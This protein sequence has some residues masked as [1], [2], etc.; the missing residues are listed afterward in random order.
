MITKSAR[1]LDIRIRETLPL[2]SGLTVDLQ[3]GIVLPILYRAKV[4]RS[5]LVVFRPH[6]EDPGNKIML[7]IGNLS[8][9]M[10]LSGYR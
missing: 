6:I 8:L 10:V 3:N 9:T 5:S 1:Y 2:R 7:A 4:E